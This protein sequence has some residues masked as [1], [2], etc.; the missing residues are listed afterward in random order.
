MTHDAALQMA[1][2]PCGNALALTS[3]N[4]D[5]RVIIFVLSG[6]YRHSIRFSEMTPSKPH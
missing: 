1:V 6:H 3:L 4:A 2:W 5:S